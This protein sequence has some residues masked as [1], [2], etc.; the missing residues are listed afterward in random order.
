MT[1]EFEKA[2]C[3]LEAETQVQRATGCEP[4]SGWS[5]REKSSLHFSVPVPAQ[6]GLLYANEDAMGCSE[7]R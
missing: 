4:R 5:W 2:T 1:V 7:E 6:G 3:T